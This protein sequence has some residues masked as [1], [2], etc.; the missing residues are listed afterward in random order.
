MSPSPFSRDGREM[1]VDI[2]M[3]ESPASA[4]DAKT[5]TNADFEFDV[6][7]VT[8]MDRIVRR[9]EKGQTGVLV[10]SKESGGWADIAGLATGDLVTEIGGYVVIDIVSFKKAM[11]AVAK[12]KPS[13]VRMFVRRGRRTT[14]IFVEPDWPTTSSDDG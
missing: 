3:E 6:R 12:T 13:V 7:A 2:E 11:A 5:V 8:F 10:T 9:W 1:D 4:I 14:F